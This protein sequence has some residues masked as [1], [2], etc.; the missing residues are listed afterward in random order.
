MAAKTS[1]KHP[2][3]AIEHRVIDSP[4]YASL[5]FSARSLLVLI[6]RQLSKD[7]NGHLQATYSYLR[8]FGFGSEHTISRCIKELISRGMIYRSRSGGYQQG[9][10]QY[11]VT[12]L[13]IKNRQGLFLDGF[14]PCAWRDWNPD[15]KNHPL[16][17]CRTSTAKMAYGLPLQLQKMQ[18]IAPPKAQTMN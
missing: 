13:S 2:Y 4:A 1:T 10:A 16:Q 12:W 6:T 11:A 15:E 3:A 9:A 18:L 17:K 5:S 8:R 7:N 14:N